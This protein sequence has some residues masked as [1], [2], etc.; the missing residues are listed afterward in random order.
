MYEVRDLKKSHKRPSGRKKRVSFD[1]RFTSFVSL[2]TVCASAAR[3]INDR[4]TVI[5]ALQY[6]ENYKTIVVK[7]QKTNIK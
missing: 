3:Y 5:K 1:R 6:P 7:E 2:L 4:H